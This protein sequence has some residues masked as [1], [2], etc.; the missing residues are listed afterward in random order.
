MIVQKYFRKWDKNYLSLTW[1][2]VCVITLD[3]GFIKIWK[4][5]RFVDLDE[6]NIFCSSAIFVWLHLDD[7]TSKILTL[8]IS[9]LILMISPWSDQ[10]FQSF[11]K[12]SMHLNEIYNF[13][14]N[15]V[16]ARIF[17]DDDNDE[18]LFLE[19]KHCKNW[20][21][22]LKVEWIIEIMIIR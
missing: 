14:S 7:E 2:L 19:M 5:Y 4:N 15:D 20:N 11:L 21:Q 18:T 22:Y 17:F 8:K 1:K 3:S 13:A 6:I 16:S 9:N 10:M 12:H